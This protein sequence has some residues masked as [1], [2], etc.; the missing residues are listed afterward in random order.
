[1]LADVDGN[2]LSSLA[3]EK[4]GIQKRI[5]SL[6]S[7]YPEILQARKANKA[8]MEELNGKL[9]QLA[10]KSSEIRKQYSI[11][12]G[13]IDIIVNEHTELMRSGLQSKSK[14]DRY[15]TRLSELEAHKAEKQHV[16]VEHQ[17]MALEFCDQ[18]EITED[19]L[20]GLTTDKIEK[21]LRNLQKYLEERNKDLGSVE[22]AMELYEEKRRIFD[23]V[24]G[25]VDQ[26]NALVGKLSNIYT[27][28]LRS[29]DE[30]LT[31]IAIRTKLNFIWLLTHRRYKGSIKF[32]HNK[33]LLL[34]DIQTSNRADA[35]DDE[36][37]ARNKVIKNNAKELYKIYRMAK[38]R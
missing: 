7:Q 31:L 24:K 5:E 33:E 23:G 6:T 28:R 25:E 18:R 17:E 16:F 27:R 1:M 30:F 26:I 13:D 36:Q 11:V 22:E 34:L 8:S 14:L 2:I 4:D 10:E 21:E 19:E 35:E 9:S 37:E 38:R 12:R 20:N 3:V 29:W 15:E 32:D